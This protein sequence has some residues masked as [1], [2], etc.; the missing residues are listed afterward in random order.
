MIR[1]SIII[2]LTVLTVQSVAQTSLEVQANQVFQKTSIRVSKGETYHIT[3]HGQWQDA[4][5]TPTDANGF[6]G[7]TTPMFFGMLLKPKPAQ[8]YMKLCGKVADWKFAIGTDTTIT[9]KRN[10][11]LE[12]FPNDAKGFFGNNSG[13]LKV[14]VIRT[15]FDRN[16]TYKPYLK[17]DGTFVP[18]NAYA[19]V[20]RKMWRGGLLVHGFEAIGYGILAVLPSD[21]SGWKAGTFNNYGSNLKRAW[22]NPP[23]FDHDVWY[24]N[25][26]GHPY[27]GTFFYNAVRSQ[28]A[29][30]WESSLFCLG[31]VFVW[32]Y[33]IEAGL[34]QPSIQDLIVTPIAGIGLGELI[35]FG[36]MKM[37]K[38]GLKWYEAIVVTVINPTFI[39]NNGYRLGRYN[40]RWNQND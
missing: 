27:Q 9:M 29:K 25:Y 7:F 10:G 40:S 19:P 31:Q 14:D 38:N 34:E 26:I 39:L 23:V 3:A 8:H 6:K 16:M 11:E 24:I 35:H 32:E 4:G 13:S 30:I 20:A 22:T 2:G 5:F 17:E 1:W 28:N 18:R 12:L 37:A 15:G 33:V 36:T 21:I